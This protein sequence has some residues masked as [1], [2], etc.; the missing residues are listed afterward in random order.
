LKLASLGCLHRLRTSEEWIEIS[1]LGR[2]KERH[3]TLDA[4]HETKTNKAKDATPKTIKM[5]NT[6]HTYQNG[7]HWPHLSKW[8]TLTTPIKMDN[9][10]NYQN[11]QH[12]PHLSKWTTLTT[13]IKRGTVPEFMCL[14]REGSVCFLWNHLSATR[15]RDL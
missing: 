15:S 9:T 2:N 8:T 4:A 11:G 12:W 13:P 5:D 3:T 6:D 1:E 14:H 10:E 7:Q